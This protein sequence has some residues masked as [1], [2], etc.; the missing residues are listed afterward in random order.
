MRLLVSCIAPSLLAVSGASSQSSAPRLHQEYRANDPE[1]RLLAYYSAAMVFSPAGSLPLGARWTV[2]LE[3]SWIPMLSASQRRPGIDKPE[4]T[5]LAPLLP[6]PRLSVRTA[7]ATFEASWVPPVTVAHARAN[8]FAFAA[9]RSV[10]SWHGFAFMPRLSIVGGRVQGAITCNRGTVAGGGTALATYYAAVCHG[11]DSD[12]WFEPRLAAAEIVVRRVL[13]HGGEVPR[14]SRVQAWLA[15]GG[16]AD[17]SRFDI[18]VQRADG[19][20]DLDHPVLQLRAMR[21]HASVGGAWRLGGRLTAAM[22]AFYA[23]GSLATLRMFGGV[24]GGRR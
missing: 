23:P 24:S 18:G 3:G 15:V 14:A 10:G 21:P 19:S 13:S 5:N 20:R 12:D 4:T 8:L 7:L 1:G 6:R 16:R 2:G 22:E 17:R 11:R 9:S